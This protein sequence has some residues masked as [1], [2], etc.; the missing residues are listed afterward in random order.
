MIEAENSYRGD[1]LFYS[2]HAPACR[3]VSFYWYGDAAGSLGLIAQFLACPKQFQ[4]GVL[5]VGFPDKTTLLLPF[6]LQ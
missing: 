3:G 5:R 1:Y 4:N 2:R 6:G